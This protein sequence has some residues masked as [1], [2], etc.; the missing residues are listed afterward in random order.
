MSLFDCYWMSA[1]AC[2]MSELLVAWTA[3]R[4]GED[5]TLGN[6]VLGI[7]L[8]VAPVVNSIVAVIIIVTWFSTYAGSIVLFRGRNKRH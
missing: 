6:V 8:A 3:V 7:F 4:E 1:V 2:V 5:V